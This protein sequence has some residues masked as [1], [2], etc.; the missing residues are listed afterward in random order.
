MLGFNVAKFMDAYSKSCD[1]LILLC[2][3][4][5][6]LHFSNLLSIE[7]NDGVFSGQMWATS[8]KFF[9]DVPYKMLLSCIEHPHLTIDR[10]ISYPLNILIQ[11]Y[12]ICLGTL[13]FY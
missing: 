9:I 1:N 8:S 7:A 10:L 4:I 13:M 2:A 5:W 12:A 6:F 11:F 3:N